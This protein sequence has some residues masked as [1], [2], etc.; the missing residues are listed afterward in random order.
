[1]AAGPF[2]I[3]SSK[4]KGLIE[5]LQLPLSLPRPLLLQSPLPLPL[6]LTAIAAAAA[7]A[8]LG[9][10]QAVIFSAKK[11]ARTLQQFC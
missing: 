7:I 1:V 8:L 2:D 5:R 11:R 4:K 3:T 6:P 10:W 9:N